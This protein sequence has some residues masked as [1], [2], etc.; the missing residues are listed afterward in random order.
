MR[1]LLATLCV[2]LACGNPADKNGDGIA[3]GVRT[4]SDVTQ[5]APSTPVGTLS[6][7]TVNSD[8]TPLDLV[9]VQVIVGGGSG[10]DGTPFKTASKADGSF[11][12]QNLPAGSTVQVTLSKMGYATAHLSA[13]VPG[14]AGMF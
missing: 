1:T 14:A 6:G 7:Q 4:P 13:Q 9:D 8:F 12:I 3:D 11:A 10:P 2:L 5:V